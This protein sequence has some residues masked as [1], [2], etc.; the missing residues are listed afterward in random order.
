[1]GSDGPAGQPGP[2]AERVLG[3]GRRAAGAARIHDA[4]C[5]HSGPQRH[6]A[7]CQSGGLAGRVSGQDGGEC[8]RHGSKEETQAGLS[9]EVQGKKEGGHVSD[10]LWLRVCELC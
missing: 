9:G 6:R 4:P 1:M 10:C 3:A 5:A 7:D 2:D 8:K